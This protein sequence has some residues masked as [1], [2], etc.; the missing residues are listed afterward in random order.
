MEK[1]YDLKKDLRLA[2]L[3]KLAKCVGV[4]GHNSLSKA[5]VCRLIAKSLSDGNKMNQA[6]INPE[7]TMAKKTNTVC[8]LINLLFSV[9]F[10]DRFLCLNAL[11]NRTSHETKQTYKSFWSD[12]FKA[13]QNKEDDEDLLKIYG[14]EKDEHL[15]ALAEDEN[16]NFREFTGLSEEAIRT[17]V[18]DLFKVRGK[19]ISNMTQPS[20]V[21]NNCVWD[22]VQGALEKGKNRITKDAA[23]Y[24]YLRCNDHAGIDA[25]FA[26]V[27]SDDVKGSTEEIAAAPSS[28]SSIATN[29]R[30]YPSEIL[31]M[32]N[33]GDED[34]RV[35]QEIKRGNTIKEQQYDRMEAQ[36]NRIATSHE[37]IAKTQRIKAQLSI[38]QSQLQAAMFMKN[39]E[40]V[41]KY[42]LDLGKFQELLKDV[43]QNGNNNDS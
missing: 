33:G 39:E 35:Y 31:G 38:V 16:I 11:H 34:D 14:V 12:I 36:Q 32:M 8:R 30:P 3:R 40:L 41:A 42:S 9:D 7:K 6:G 23:Y 1:K 37:E 15:Q 29:K 27:L 2:Q 24:F 43:S 25:S 20:G 4:K 5:M 28:A 22:F 17:H 19:I 21:H 10:I 18:Q 26:Q 13:F